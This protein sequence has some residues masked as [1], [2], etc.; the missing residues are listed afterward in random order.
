MWIM[1]VVWPVTALYSGPLGVWAYY[2]MGRLS[3]KQHVH[4]E[5]GH[6]EEKPGER[7]PSWQQV[8]VAATHCGSGCTVGDIAA[9][10]VLV[11]APLVLF[12]RRLYGSWVVDFLFAYALGIVFQYFTIAPM[13]HL[14]VDKGILAAVRADT[15][16]LVA[17]QVGMYGWMAVAVFLI[18]CHELKPT[19]SVFWFMMQVGMLCGFLASY[20]VNWWLLTRGWKEKM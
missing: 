1:N 10:W 4:R 18:F 12:G 11:A 15:L 8:A 16:S 6:G 3:T 13:C 9:E 7:K 2:R 5:M 20:P 17:W 14:S 19:D